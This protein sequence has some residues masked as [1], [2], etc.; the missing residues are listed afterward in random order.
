MEGGTGIT[1]DDSTMFEVRR[2]SH[3]LGWRATRPIPRGTCLLREKPLLVL[4]RQEEEEHG[5]GAALVAKFN[6]LSDRD[7]TT[8]MALYVRD[9]SITPRTDRNSFHELL[10]SSPEGEYMDLVMRNHSRHLILMRIFST[11]CVRMGP[12]A[13]HGCGIFPTFSRIN[14]SCT[15]NASFHY[16]QGSGMASIHCHQDLRQGEEITASYIQPCQTSEKRKKCLTFDCQCTVYAGPGREESDSRRKRLARIRRTLHINCKEA[17]NDSDEEISDVDPEWRA[18]KSLGSAEAVALAEEYVAILEQ[19]NLVGPSLTDGY[20]QLSVCHIM[21]G[22][23]K[24]AEEYSLKAFKNA[25]ACNGEAGATRLLWL[26]R[27][28]HRR[29]GST[30]KA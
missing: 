8:Y 20:E 17:L 26:S 12:R 28:I 1:S 9:N 21:N 11:N 15:P 24:E 3:G 2:S 22:D 30:D 23:K 4:T 10:S 16:D 25:Q 7:K 18:A 29:F 13:E 19:E 6:Q 27:E 14:H 5:F